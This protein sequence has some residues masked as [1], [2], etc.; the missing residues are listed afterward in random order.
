MPG[1]SISQVLKEY[2]PFDENLIVK[3]S[4]QLLKGLNYLHT[5]SPPI[6]HRDIKGG[7]VLIGRGDV[8][9]WAD[10]GCS[11]RMDSEKTQTMLRGSIPWMAPEVVAHS[12][13][14]WFSDVWSFGCL[15][16]E[17][18]TARQPWGNFENQVAALMK[19]GMSNETP[20]LPE[21]VSDDIQDF[22]TQCCQRDYQKRPNTAELLLHGMLRGAPD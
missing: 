5:Q 16:I 20:P 14:G 17:V 8:V 10:F 2:G 21:G 1:G 19:I 6:I 9:K 15:V 13:Y 3:Y 7:N 4:K 12:R 18:G 22:I 11:K